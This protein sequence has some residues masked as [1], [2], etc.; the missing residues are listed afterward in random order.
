MDL[1][2]AYAKFLKRGSKASRVQKRKVMGTVSGTCEG[3][4]EANGGVC[5][6]KLGWI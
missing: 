6:P 4:S 2:K 1:D 3:A 5:L